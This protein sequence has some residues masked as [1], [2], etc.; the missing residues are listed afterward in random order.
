MSVLAAAGATP[1]SP[2]TAVE[3]LE[4]GTTS[5]TKGNKVAPAAS[6]DDDSSAPRL[7]LEKARRPSW[8]SVPDSFKKAI[9][10][11][12]LADFLIGTGQVV[13]SD[14][15]LM[16]ARPSDKELEILDKIMRG[17]EVEGVSKAHL[18]P[19]PMQRAIQA[20]KE[21][22]MH[23]G[24]MCLQLIIPMLAGAAWLVW[25]G[26]T[27]KEQ[28]QTY[29]AGMTGRLAD[30]DSMGAHY[31]PDGLFL[32]ELV[33]LWLG[34]AS[35]YML[36]VGVYF[37]MFNRRTF[38]KPF[39]RLLVPCLILHGGFATFVRLGQRDDG[40]SGFSKISVLIQ[41]VILLGTI[42][43]ASRIVM[44]VMKLPLWTVG[45]CILFFSLMFIGLLYQY[46]LWDTVLENGDV[47]K[48]VA[49]VMV[50][51]LVFEILLTGARFLV[52]TVE[53]AHE[54]TIVHVVT[55]TMALKKMYGRFIIGMIKSQSIIVLSSVL[56]G[57]AEIS[58]MCSLGARDRFLYR[59]LG[60]RAQGGD[61]LTAMK[62]NRLMRSR[63]AH[64]ETILEIIFTI[65]M[66]F[67]VPLAYDVGEGGDG[68]SEVGFLVS[69]VVIQ[70]AIEI[71]V[72]L[73]VVVYLTSMVKQPMMAITHTDFNGWTYWM[74]IVCVWACTFTH[75]LVLGYVVGITGDH[76]ATLIYYD[77]VRFKNATI[78]MVAA[79]LTH[80]V[81]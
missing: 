41:A 62:K 5:N 23:F 53:H 65:L 37:S 43:K 17:E 74:I 1:G 60:K 51:P 50:N 45:G 77:D 7:P 80:C 54:S 46:F 44:R 38:Q 58:F 47:F 59:H 52:R 30:L 68:R 16:G 2:P 29:P 70:I 67:V 73:I 14:A 63:N 56:L 61:P 78:D 20:V 66:G 71:L 72:D 15:D 69:N 6:S 9:R 34:R 35:Y 21:F 24:R 57:I 8:D 40:C 4:S 13:T 22:P 28:M 25:M 55:I 10:Q 39:L 75:G 79:N 48:L 19:T 27:T 3:Q 33:S 42:Y 76:E 11:P 26:T 32:R 18:M 49:G 31:W 81:A 36:M 12:R 64:M